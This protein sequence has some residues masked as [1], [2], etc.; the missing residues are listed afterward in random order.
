MLEGIFGNR[1][2]GKVL[3]HLYHSGEIHAP[4]I[5]RDWG[6]ALTPVQNQLA[7]F[8]R[9]GVLVSRKVGQT[10]L[11]QFNPKSFFTKPVRDIV[12]IQ[13]DT[14][15]PAEREAIFTTRNRPRRPGKPVIRHARTS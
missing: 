7:R 15:P 6:I 10:R 4:A 2:A 9:A 14:L 8:E 13:Y 12:R 1:T 11:Y 3:L 5:A